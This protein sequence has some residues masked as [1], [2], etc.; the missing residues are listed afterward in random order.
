[1]NVYG[2]ELLF[3]SGL[4]N[5]FDHSDGDR[6]TSSVIAGGLLLFGI[7]TLTGGAKA[8]INFTRALFTSDYATALPRDQVVLELLENIDPDSE[9]L[10]ACRRVKDL[11]YT[12][13]LDDFVYHP[14]Y[15]PLLDY[16]D[17]IKVD[18]RLSGPDERRDLAELVRPMGIRLLAEKVETQEEFDQAKAM[19]YSLFQ[20]YFFCKPLLLSRRDLPGNKLHYLQ[21]LKEIN[22]QDVDFERV[23][24]AIRKDVPLAYKLLRYINAA[25][26]GMKRE[27]TS[28]NQ[29]VA[30]LGEREVRKW[31]SLMALTQMAEDKPAELMISSLFRAR[32]TEGLAGSLGMK[33]RSA[34]L[35]LL[36]LLS[37]VDAILDRPMKD[38]VEELPLFGDIKDA[39]LTRANRPGGLL[40]LVEAM[41]KGEWERL[42]EVIEVLD[43]E[44]S[45]LPSLYVEA[46]AT[47]HRALSG[48]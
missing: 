46:V 25:A 23:A 5:F 36:G 20:G 19:G 14:K 40:R 45:Q 43:I 3:R 9:I 1:M 39:L 38:I 17:I 44:E 12:L 31:A 8:F 10:D 22:R 42:D 21:L 2:Y 32:M 26:F 15:R 11:K 35:F 4:D 33:E 41:E 18:F 16:A 7:E 37:L 24:D 27:I 48:S 30:L 29:A 13:A 28:I 34:D 47:A 6:A